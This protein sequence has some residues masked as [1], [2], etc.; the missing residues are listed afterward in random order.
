LRDWEERVGMA[1]HVCH[2]QVRNRFS[3]L[4]FVSFQLT[5]SLLCFPISLYGFFF[6]GLG[7]L[8]NA[9]TCKCFILPL[10]ATTL[11]LLFTVG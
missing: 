8:G 5:L 10:I 4:Y 3:E 9:I 2:C 7:S 11:I 6:I 1:P